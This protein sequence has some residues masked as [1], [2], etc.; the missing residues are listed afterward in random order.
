[1]EAAADLRK[2]S[3]ARRARDT[4]LELERLRPQGQAYLLRNFGHSL[5][6]ADAE[7]AVA[8]VVIRLHGKIV[9]GQA[10]A[11][12]R[13]AFFTSVRNAAIDQL[14]SRAARPTAALEAAAEAPAE[15]VAPA[16]SAVAREEAIRLQEVLGR[17]RANY[18][19]AIV[20]RFGLGLTVPQIAARLQISLPAA[21]KLVLRATEQARRRL[22]SIEGEEF[23]AEMRELARRSFLAKQLS[24]VASVEEQRLLHQHL[25]HCGRCRSF[26]AELR[27]GLHEL[28][29]GAILA[30][31]GS[32]FAPHLGIAQQ[33]GRWLGRA[34]EAAQASAARLRLTALRTGTLLSGGDGSGAGALAGSTQK[35]LAICGAATASAATCLATGII[36]PGVGAIGS[37]HSHPAQRS[38][39]PQVR[40]VSEAPP[41]EAPQPQPSPAVEEPPPPS[42]P[43]QSKPAES[44]PAPEPNPTPSQQASEEFGFESG[45]PA[46]ESP[47]TPEPS[48]PAPPPSSASAGPSGAGGGGGGEHFGFAG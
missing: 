40:R 44:A 27:H 39:A 10:P 26:F 33:L 41:P 18:R 6:R 14:R 4:E 46:P 34:S 15:E 11:N 21:K 43:A 20:L 28:G 2:L 38:P 19:E 8:E 36:G 42:D 32:R 47:P 7:D 30:G 22:H 1:M 48:A 12:L 23:C 35:A 45:A 29:A 37:G 17:M 13:A 5:G 24:G 16:E 9:A 31:A 3:A 25:Q